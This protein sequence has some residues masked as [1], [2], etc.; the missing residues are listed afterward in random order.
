MPTILRLGPY[1]LYFY[2]H[3]PNEPPHV[4]IDRDTSSAKFWLEPVSLA[5]NLGFSAKELRKLQS[6]VQE[7][8][9]M[10]LEAWYGYFGD[11]SGRES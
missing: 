9:Q 1:R 2:S 5:N 11:S 8:Q 6:I 4:H 7:N 10:L 3:E